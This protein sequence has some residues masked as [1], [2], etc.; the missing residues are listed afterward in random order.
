MPSPDEVPRKSSSLGARATRGMVNCRV[1]SVA[2]EELA[3]LTRGS[4]GLGGPDRSARG[5]AG[6]AGGGVVSRAA[7]PE[8]SGEPGGTG[9]DSGTTGAEDCATTARGPGSDVGAAAERAAVASSG[10]MGGNAALVASIALPDGSGA[11][12][13][14]AT[15]FAERRRGNDFGPVAGVDREASDWATVP[16]LAG[17]RTRSSPDLPS[18]SAR[19]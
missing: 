12:K 3:G 4:A 11:A 18:R 17:W 1:V 14:P 7:W 2:T 10:R 15:A 5:L 9:A 8:R 6:A 16:D 13:P 19:L